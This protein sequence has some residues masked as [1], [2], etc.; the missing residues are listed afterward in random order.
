MVHLRSLGLHCGSVVLG[1]LPLACARTESSIEEMRAPLKASTATTQDQCTPP[2]LDNKYQLGLKKGM[3]LVSQKWKHFEFCDQ[4]E[5]FAD[6]VLV[7]I[8]AE[9]ASTGADEDQLGKRCRH[10][11]FLDG[12]FAGLDTVQQYCSDQCFMR[13]NFIGT[14][15]AITY[16]NVVIDTAGALDPEPWVRSPVSVCGLEFNLACDAEFLRATTSYTNAFGSCT[17]YTEPPYW[18]IW[19]R[20][21]LKSCD[22]Y[23]HDGVIQ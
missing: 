23:N 22:Y 15:E 9:L 16:C 17:R 12:M 1:F 8:D 19:N 11:G 7:D 5:S 4:V 18:D 21:R 20:T 3:K 14:L 13:G 6:S 2:K 10:A